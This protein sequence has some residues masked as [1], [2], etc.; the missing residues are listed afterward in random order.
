M[1]HETPTVRIVER[2]AA[3]LGVPVASFYDPREPSPSDDE[4]MQKAVAAL[5]TAFAAVRDPGERQ[6]SVAVMDAE[7]ERLRDLLDG[8]DKE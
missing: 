7:A 4:A 8:N 2:I 3:E 6:H 5:L 1:E